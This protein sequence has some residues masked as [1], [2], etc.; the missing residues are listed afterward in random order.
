MFQHFRF[1]TV[2]PDP[3]WKSLKF[4]M[5]IA[6]LYFEVRFLLPA[7]W[8]PDMEAEHH[9][10]RRWF[11]EFEKSPGRPRAQNWFVEGSLEVKLPTIWT[12]GKAE[13][14]RVRDEKKR[15]EKIREERRCRCA[16]SVFFQRFVAQEGRKV[17]SLKRRVRSQLAK[18]EIKNCMPLWCE[19]HFQVKMYKTHQVR[20]AFS[21]SDVEKAYA[22]V[23]RSTFP[24]QKYKNLRV[25]SFFDVRERMHT[26]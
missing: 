17:V 22:V 24:S 25:L 5:I 9:C 19:A 15:S 8:Q 23:A 7:L 20:T 10:L 26:N 12:D 21:R 6:C 3:F 2:S 18:W 14:G 11:E 13:V 1:S 4:E 16:K